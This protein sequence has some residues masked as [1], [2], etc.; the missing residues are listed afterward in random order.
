MLGQYK[1]HLKGVEYTSPGGLLAISHVVWRVMLLLVPFVGVLAI[2][3]T[4]LGLP[5]AAA[6]LFSVMI[7]VVVL[8]TMMGVLSVTSLV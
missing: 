2:S 1:L 3:D 4:T 6:P 7:G 5:L 8:D